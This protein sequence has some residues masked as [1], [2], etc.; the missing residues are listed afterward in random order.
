MSRR[1]TGRVSQGDPNVDHPEH[2][3]SHPSGIECIDVVQHMNFNLGNAIKYIWRASDKGNAIQDLEK[4]R[5]Y[6]DKEIER[7]LKRN[8]R[9][10]E[11]W[12]QPRVL[13]GNNPA[14]Q[15]SP[16]STKEMLDEAAAQRKVEGGQS[17]FEKL[18]AEGRLAG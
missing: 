6:L 2:Y 3:N 5:W 11:D 15:K 16:S 1:T 10:Q 4:A 17:R 7:V 18:A 14:P 9:L 12:A 8:E 13:H